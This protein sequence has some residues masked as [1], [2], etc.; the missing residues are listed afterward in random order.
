MLPRHEYC[1]M[2]CLRYVVILFIKWNGSRY[3]NG[4]Q[5]S[6]QIIG[7]SLSE[8]HM[9]TSGTVLRNPPVYTAKTT[10]SRGIAPICGP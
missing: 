2:W 3:T 10:V 8:L 1:T 5:L 7:A 9:H 6:E 4:I